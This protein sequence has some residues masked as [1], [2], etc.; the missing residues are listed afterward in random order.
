[1]QEAVEQAREA[2]LSGSPDRCLALTTVAMAAAATDAAVL[3]KR[4]SDASAAAVTAPA[5]AAENRAGRGSPAGYGS[6]SAATLLRQL[7][8]LQVLA[9]IELV[10]GSQQSWWRVSCGRC[11]MSMLHMKTVEERALAC[12]W[13]KGSIKLQLRGFD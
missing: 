2:L 13:H 4:S 9:R 5:P 6:P 1:M 8:Q 3:N 7:Q 11:G 12:V 10:S